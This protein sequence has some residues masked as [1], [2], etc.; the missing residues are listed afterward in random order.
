[1]DG[2]IPCTHLCSLKKK[3]D[4]A[5]FYILWSNALYMFKSIKINENENEIKTLEDKMKFKYVMLMNDIQRYK[6]LTVVGLYASFTN[7]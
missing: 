6:H 3:L 1:M 5:T 4:V 2:K 7:I